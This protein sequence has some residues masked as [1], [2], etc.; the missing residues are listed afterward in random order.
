M[1][2]HRQEKW[3]TIE[4]LPIYLSMIEDCVV[5]TEESYNNFIQAREKPHVL[6]D[7]IIDRAIKIYT[8]QLNHV[9]YYEAQ[10]ARWKTGDLTI[11]QH[12]AL[13]VL[14]YRIGKLRTIT[15]KTL[16]LVKEL[17]EGTINRIMEMEDGELG[18]NVLLGKVKPPSGTNYSR[19]EAYKNLTDEHIKT[20]S[21]L[22]VK[23]RELERK[24]CNN[25]EILKKMYHQ[26][27]KFKTLMDAVGNEGLELLGARFSGFYHYTMI[28]NNLAGGLASGKIKAPD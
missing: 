20:A 22:D 7:A 21:D 18:F 16:S 14:S 4:K 25:I 19:P 12:R 10:A 6:D 9:D 5:D 11:T 8:E 13:D 3:H 17:R 2:P 27:P 28:L 1:S 15:E 24:G 26:M 23:V